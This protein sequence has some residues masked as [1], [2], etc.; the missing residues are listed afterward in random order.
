MQTAKQL[1]SCRE[2]W[3]GEE[4]AESWAL[5]SVCQGREST[6]GTSLLQTLDSTY[7]SVQGAF[8]APEEGLWFVTVVFLRRLW[9][10]LCLCSSPC[11]ACVFFWGFSHYGRVVSRVKTGKWREKEMGNHATNWFQTEDVKIL[12]PITALVWQLYN[13]PLDYI[14]T[15]R[16]FCA[17]V[18]VFSLSKFIRTWPFCSVSL[19]CFIS[20]KAQSKQL[21]FK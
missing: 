5:G 1:E 4:A 6:S 18:F 8:D 14:R 2:V 10:V 12:G 15:K 16:L 11:P 9:L 3:L 7:P 19:Y 13:A 17:K 21:L 20:A